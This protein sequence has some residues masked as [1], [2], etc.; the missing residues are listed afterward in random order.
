M[1][2]QEERRRRTRSALQEAARSLVL[3][4]GLGGLTVQAI[5]DRAGVARGTF[6]V[7]FPDP[8]AALGAVLDETFQELVA[9]TM[10]YGEDE[11]DQKWRALFGFCHENRALFL[12]LMGPE[13]HVQFHDRATALVAGMARIEIARGARVPLPGTD[14]DMVAE[15]FAGAFMRLAMWSLMQEAPPEEVSQTFFTMARALFVESDA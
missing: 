5:V 2:R 13:G 4:V 8:E 10:H 7:Y 6:Y 15:F 1:T 9:R 14:P 3:E 12:A 11:R